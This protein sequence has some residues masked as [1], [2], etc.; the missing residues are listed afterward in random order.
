MAK[1]FFVFIMLIV[2]LIGG[3]AAISQKKEDF[4][5]GVTLYIPDRQI[6][7]DKDIPPDVKLV[8]AALINKIRGDRDVIP[9]VQFD[10]AG[11]HDVGER[12]FQYE[13]YDLKLV[14]LTRFES[15]S[16]GSAEARAQMEGVFHF[17]DIIGRRVSTYFAATYSKTQDGVT[18]N[19]SATTGVA[20]VYPRIEGYFVP[21]GAVEQMEKYGLDSFADLYL[22]A[23]DHAMTMKPTEAERRD[24]EAYEKMGLWDRI[25]TGIGGEEDYYL[26]AFCM[27]RIS[28]DAVLDMKVTN[29]PGTM[30]SELA[31]VLY[32][33]E[34]GWRIMIA[35]GRFKLD[36]PDN[37][38]YA[39]ISYVGDP[40]SGEEPLLVA[41]FKNEK[42]YSL[43]KSPQPPAA[44][45]PVLQPP[46]KQAPAA[47]QKAPQTPSASGERFL[48]PSNHADALIIQTRLKELGF[49][50]GIIDGKFGPLSRAA[51][52]KFISANGMGDSAQWTPQVQRRLFEGSR[53]I[54]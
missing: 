19:N 39:S 51:L 30:D 10:R 6:L 21:R 48:N 38:F 12:E 37:N 49:Y 36:S 14:D 9:D 13:G 34:N 41:C 42:D 24:R 2:F 27:D 46:A 50:K 32:V 28:S 35:G 20:P 15:V 33:I 53:L 31:E 43:R 52:G 8:L 22:F 1:R 3:C 5:A 47:A 4:G 18:I 16:V 44:Q 45:N 25:K 26:I 17:E 29:R 40:Q 54:E 11:F 7:N 23:I